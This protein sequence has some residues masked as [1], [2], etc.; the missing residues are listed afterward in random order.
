MANFVYPSQLMARPE[1]VS[2]EPEVATKAD[3]SITQILNI[4][5]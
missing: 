2:I 5:M 1:F 4:H 3:I